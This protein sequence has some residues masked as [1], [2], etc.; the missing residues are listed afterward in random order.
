MYSAHA[1]S[2]VLPISYCVFCLCLTEIVLV[3]YLVIAE[4]LWLSE[5]VLVVIMVI[6]YIE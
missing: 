3:G 5:F 4:M 6:R 2:I 1:C